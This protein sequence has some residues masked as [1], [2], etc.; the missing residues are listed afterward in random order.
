MENGSTTLNKFIPKIIISSIISIDTDIWYFPE[1]TS[2][3]IKKRIGSR[4]IVITII[5]IND[6][7]NFWLNR[8]LI[9]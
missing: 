3:L 2:P 8:L 6:N 7:K 5:C 4:K 1:V 9:K